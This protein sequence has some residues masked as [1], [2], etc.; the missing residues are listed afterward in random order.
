MKNGPKNDEFIDTIQAVEV[1]PILAPNKIRILSLKVIIPVLTNDT[2][3]VD[4]NVLDCIMAVTMPPKKNPPKGS[5]V[6]F[7]IH[8]LNL[9]TPKFSISLL[10]LCKP[11]T[12]NEI[13]A[14]IKI[15]A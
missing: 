10:K 7:P 11:K 2:V 3:K 12:N 8:L 14:M 13:D 5:W 15:I 6:T 9:A 1:V 4:T